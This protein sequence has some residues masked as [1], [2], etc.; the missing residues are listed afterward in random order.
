VA[1][2]SDDGS[3]IISGTFPSSDYLQKLD[4]DGYKLSPSSTSVQYNNSSYHRGGAPM[5][6][7]G[8]GGAILLSD[9]DRGAYQD[10]FGYHNVALYLQRVDKDGLVG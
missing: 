5:A 6:R 10:Q 3:L 1:L 4:L 8:N 2:V 7:D 9:D